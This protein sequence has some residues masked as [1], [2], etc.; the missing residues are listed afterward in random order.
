MNFLISRV[1]Y[2]YSPFVI[3]SEKAKTPRLNVTHFQI[4][5]GH[6]YSVEVEGFYF[7]FLGLH[8]TI[9]IPDPT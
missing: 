4:L 6:V 3:Q 5:H 8:D 9:W 2:F 7:V 1:Q